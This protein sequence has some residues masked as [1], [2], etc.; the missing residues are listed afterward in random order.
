M[1]GTAQHGT[2]RAQARKTTNVPTPREEEGKGGRE[3]G[4]GKKRE[5]REGQTGKR[6]RGAK[7][8]GREKGGAV[9]ARRGKEGKGGRTQTEACTPASVHAATLI[10]CLILPPISS[11]VR[12]PITTAEAFSKACLDPDSRTQYTETKFRKLLENAETM[13]ST[14]KGSLTKIVHAPPTPATTGHVLVMG[15][16]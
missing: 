13:I 3:R 2:H 15:E 6:R 11:F 5:E 4:R 14:F 16:K 10:N 8:E 1:N 9:G 12:L 7:E